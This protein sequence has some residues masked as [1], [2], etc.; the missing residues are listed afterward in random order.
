MSGALRDLRDGIYEHL[1]TTEVARA[2]DALDARATGRK[3]ERAG[4][5]DH[6]LPRALARHLAREIE[7]RLRAL[8]DPTEGLRLANA[9]LAALEAG[10]GAAGDGARVERAERL[11]SV[12]ARLPP[13]RPTTPLAESTL[14]TRSRTD[15]TL[16][17][18][19]KRELASADSVD[20]IAAFV[21]VGGVRQLWPELEEL[22]RRGGKVRVLTTVFTGSTDAQAADDLARLPGCEVRISY[23]VQ[24]TRLHAKAWLFVRDRGAE[25]LHTAYVGSANL[26]QTALSS[27]QEWTVKASSGDLPDVIRKFRGTFE[28]LWNDEEFEAYGATEPE[29][30]RL[31]A[32]LRAERGRGA[33]EPLTTLFA[34]RPHPFQR[35]ILDRL[36]AER[37]LHGHTRNLVVAA[38]GT[39]K[40]VVAAFD[41]AGVAERE[42]ARPRVLFLAHRREILEQARATFR[43]VLHD[44]AF[45]E[46]WVDGDLP[47]RFEH[48]FASVQSASRGLEERVSRGH[49]HYV[50]VD[51]CHHLPADS[52]QRVMAYLTPA[53]VLGLTATPERSDGKS[54]LPDFGGRVAAELRLWHALDKQLL[55]PFEY[56]GLA[57]STDLTKVKWSRAGYTSAE[58]T[59]LY[60]GND[61]R[62]DLVIAQLARRVASLDAVR[63]LA[64]CVS[65]EHAEFMA[66][67]LSRRGLRAVALHGGSSREERDEARG[68]LERRELQGV[69]TCDLYNEGVDLPFV[70]TL[71]LLRPT[72]S[73]TLFMQQLGRG[74]RLH[75]GKTSCLVLDFIGQHRAEFRF[76]AVYEA[77]TGLPRAAL[78]AAVEAGFPFL[79]SGCVLE[80]DAVAQGTV[81]A[82][83]R[84]QVP[85]TERLAR[86]LRELAAEPARAGRGQ[87]TLGE[88]LE[89]TGRELDDVYGAGGYTTL[90]GRAG[91]SSP[92]EETCDL[93]RRLGWLTHVDEP[94][95]F[96]TW[97][98]ALADEPLAP[99]Y[100]TRLAMLDF[101]LHHR[102]E[103]RDADTVRAYLRRPGIADE[104]RG[105]SEVLSARVPFVSDVTP[106]AEW[107][108]ALH[109][110][111][112]RREIMAAIGFV[113]VGDKGVIPQGGILKIEKEKRELL[114]VTLDKSAK[115]FSPSTHYRDYA[116]SPSL[117]HWESQSSASHTRPSGKRYTESATNGWTFHLFVR[118]DTNASYAYLGPARLK[119]WEGDR[120]LAI[121]WALEHAL[122]AALFQRF[123]DLRGG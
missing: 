71:L 24:R 50:V 116:I 120:P 106:V 61:A 118:T 81:L 63:A 76:D 82:A 18:E 35:E 16:G 108:L 67:E 101:Q 25:Q 87:P 105:L 84:R 110:H 72:A 66:R 85:T 65:V 80:L 78:H 46:L 90:L 6:D 100:A 109:R 42:G 5:G 8:G 51:E 98:A 55:V 68:K 122:P 104:L 40:T 31:R 97:R 13:K 23:D 74:L 62:V 93:S 123:S 86:E 17:H 102:G 75:P 29:R 43:H 95:R 79:P 44:G 103:L 64:F 21:T 91:L 119:S 57:D 52:Y 49:F 58:L 37:A 22:A 83:L 26:T 115:S 114:F 33:D 77:L 38:T 19:L 10:D 88:Y 107:G 34:L 117:F 30:A 7:R 32:A 15:P 54:L 45:G 20:V 94:A 41:Y 2:L 111:Y 99:A 28:A 27:G 14:L 70:D 12:Y 92:D 3:A 59:R 60:T 113:K 69:C 11:L 1:V 89:A 121:T 48:V 47:E 96:E 53:I 36:V 39:G 4:I 73:A 112:A 56:Y 9:L